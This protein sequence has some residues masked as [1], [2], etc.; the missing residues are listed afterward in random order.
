MSELLDFLRRYN[1]IF[2]FVVLEALSVVLLVRH[3]HYQ[4]SAYIS[5]ANGAAATLLATE[6]EVQSFVNLRTVNAELTETNVQ[7]QLENDALRTEL[8]RLQRD[9]TFTQRAV[10]R[11]LE[12]YSTVPATVVS[13]KVRVGTDNYIVINRGA[14]DGVRPEMGVVSGG[15]VVGIVYLTSAHNSLVIPA[16]H[17]KSSISCRVRGEDYFGYLQWDGRNTRSAHVADIPRY[18][19][20]KRGQVVETSGYSAVFPPGIFVGRVRKVSNAAD[21]QSF[22][23]DVTLGTDFANLRDVDVITTPYRA[24]MDSLL[25]VP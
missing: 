16:T 19:N 2:L 14:S 8:R 17:S 12:G 13:N 6:T 15:G 21:G 5:A 23:I 1:Y 10:M 18:A 4:G 3:N 24:E 25:A 9:T 22:R 7:L 11:R 20:A